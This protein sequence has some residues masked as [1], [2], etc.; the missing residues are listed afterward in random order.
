MN[1]ETKIR[2]PYGDQCRKRDA[3]QAVRERF[4]AQRDHLL[5]EAVAEIERIEREGV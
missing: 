5:A 4:C 3:I 2:T 1:A